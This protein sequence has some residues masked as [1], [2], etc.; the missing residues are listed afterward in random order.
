MSLRRSLLSLIATAIVVAISLFACQQQEDTPDPQE[1]RPA[2][3]MIVT[4][5]EGYLVRQ[6]P[7]KILPNKQ[8]DLSFDLSE[9]IIELPIKE[10]TFV[11]KGQILGR[12]DPKKFYD[13]YNEEKAKFALAEAQFKRAQQL[14]EKRYISRSDYDVLESQYQ[15]ALANLNIAKRNLSN[16]IMRAPFDGMVAKKY[17]ENF[18]VVQAK[19]QVLNLH[20]VSQVDIEISVPESIILNFKSDREPGSVAVYFSSNPDKKYPVKFKEFSSR[21]DPQT[22][23]YSVVYTMDVPEEINVLP[24]M[25]ATLIG[26]VPKKQDGSN[27]YYLIPS[28]A[29]FADEHK[30]P[31]VWLV[32]P[33]SLEIKQTPIKVTQMIS[34]NI[35]VTK[36]L[37]EGDR[38][39][40]AG[41]HFLNEGQRVTPMDQEPPQ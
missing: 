28:S 16:T 33:G 37:Q 38:I 4:Q 10:G 7:G 6:F 14:M 26:I 32:E 5:P 25:S 27:S 31:Y 40:I 18:E 13:K 20:N 35:R 12:L 9:R 39:V 30:Q 11:K 23:T 8:A 19:Q 41:V 29:V 1:P 22:Q 24:G 36:G 2:K 17:V 21:A 34:D 15:I 3:T